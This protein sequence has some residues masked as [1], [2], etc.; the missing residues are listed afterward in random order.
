MQG[1]FTKWKNGSL[2]VPGSDEEYVKE[3]EAATRQL[4]DLGIPVFATQDWHP[5]NHVS[6]ASGHPGKK[7]F[8]TMTIDGRT[9]VLWPSH[10]VQ[11][12]ENARVLVDNNLFLAIVKMSQDPATESYSAF[13]DG[14]GMKTE[15]DT[16]LGIN[17]VDSI[18]IYGIATE[19]VVRTTA[20]DLRSAGY[21]AI[22]ID[23]LCRGVSPNGAAA[24]IDEMKNAGVRV[25]KTLDDISEEISG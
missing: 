1:D 23:G 12:T 20:L 14:K 11:G 4:K 19:Y 9:E 8:D 17:G 5:P 6:F 21:R 22:V 13:R 16:V 10:C 2:A 3:V 25:V 24:A 15:L 7:P 18:V